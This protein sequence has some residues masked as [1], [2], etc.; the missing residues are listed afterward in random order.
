MMR[1]IQDKRIETELSRLASSKIPTKNKKLNKDEYYIEVRV[2][3]KEEKIIKEYKCIEIL[4]VI[5]VGHNFP[6]NPPKVYCRTPVKIYLKI[7]LL[8][9][10]LWWKRHFRG[11][12]GAYL[13]S[14]D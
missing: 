13:V 9:Y 4:F 10:N 3:C 2:P 12:T 6:I 1:E 11:H 8:S 5:H 7:V 14:F